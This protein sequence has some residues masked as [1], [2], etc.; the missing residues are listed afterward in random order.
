M[1]NKKITFLKNQVQL[2]ENILSSISPEERR[3]RG[4]YLIQVAIR[5]IEGKPIPAGALTKIKT[6]PKSLDEL[7]LLYALILSV[8]KL[9][10][11][12]PSGTIKPEVLKEDLKELRLPDDCASDL[13]NVLYGSKRIAFDSIIRNRKLNPKLETFNWKVNITI[14]GKHLSR[15]L[16]PTIIVEICLSN[17]CKRTFEMCVSKFHSLRFMV[18]TVLR[19]L[20]ALE[21]KRLFKV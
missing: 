16:E 10:L 15:L 4:R 3:N 6:H 12:V 9:V 7:H 14:A 1:S 18:A 5:D 11:C 8:V 2:P 17:G 20:E 13:V 21:K 19:E